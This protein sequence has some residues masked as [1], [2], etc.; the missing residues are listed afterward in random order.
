MSALDLG[1]KFERL[2][3]IIKVKAEKGTSYLEKSLVEEDQSYKKSEERA[4][5]VPSALVSRSCLAWRAVVGGC[6]AVFGFSPMQDRMAAQRCA[7]HCS[8]CDGEKG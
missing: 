8:S 7:P 6:S 1:R 2:V 3:I 5:E 4:P